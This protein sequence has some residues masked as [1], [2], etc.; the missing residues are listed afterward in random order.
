MISSIVGSVVV[1][2]LFTVTT[3]VLFVLYECVC[4]GGGGGELV[5]V[6]KCST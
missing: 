6:L 2:A 5:L 3:T 1:G 4:V